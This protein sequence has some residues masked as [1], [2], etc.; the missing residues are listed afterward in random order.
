MHG[1][2]SCQER[3]SKRAIEKIAS[4][5]R[6][7]ASSSS[8]GSFDQQPAG[9]LAWPGKSQIRFGNDAYRIEHL[10][11]ILNQRFRT[12]D[13]PAKTYALKEIFLFLNEHSAECD[14]QEG[15]LGFPKKG[16]YYPS[17]YTYLVHAKLNFSSDTTFEILNRLN[18][19][20][21]FA[22]GPYPE[23]EKQ[24][25]QFNL[26][27][28]G[29][30]IAG[31]LKEKPTREVETT[32]QYIEPPIDL[33]NIA[34]EDLPR[35]VP[36]P[37]EVLEKIEQKHQLLSEKSSGGEKSKAKAWLNLVLS[38]P[39]ITETKDTMDIR[40]A[41]QILDRDFYGMERLKRRI[42][43]EIAK[44]KQQGSNQGG[45]LLLVGPPGTGKTAIA[46]IIAES[47]GR[48]FVRRSLSGINDA[49]RITGSDYT[50][51]GSK[52]GV[53]I[54]GM[55]EVGTINPVFQID[56]MDKVG[57]LSPQGNPLD[58]L[59]AVLDPQQNHSFTDS[60]LDFPYDLSKVLFIC[61]AN[62]LE[63]FPAPLLSR[64]EVIEFHAYMPEEKMA[65]ATNCLIPKLYKEFNLSPKELRFEPEAIKRIILHYTLEGGVRKL[66]ERLKG[67]FGEACLY[68]EE[69]PGERS[70]TVTPER[71]D[72]W[73]TDP[74]CKNAVNPV[75]MRK[76][77][78]S[79]MYYSEAGGG[80]MPVEV[81]ATNGK[82]Q[83]LLTGSLG[84][85]M[86]EAAQV[87]LSY[88]RK[89]HDTL[90]LSPETL[91]TLKED[92]IDIHIHYPDGATPKDGPSAGV[93]T[94]LALWS[95]LS[96]NRIPAGIALTGEVDLKGNITAIGG[97]LEKVSGAIQQGASKIYLPQENEKT[98][99]DI[100]KRSPIFAETVKSARIRFVSNVKEL[101]DDVRQFA[102]PSKS[103][104]EPGSENAFIKKAG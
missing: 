31:I 94:F 91:K 80:I 2:S 71:V 67:I 6:F 21:F 26:S 10:L 101:V 30:K 11:P 15:P 4:P 65:I 66:E 13:R 98:F 76:G 62:K 81:S 25:V 37:P 45:I 97:V 70:I 72:E 92:E 5:L 9:S 84:D 7:T 47:M 14:G 104:A 93:S 52:T 33:K 74:I 69:H 46:K 48:K 83:L 17:R 43:R 79:G 36:F 28:Y 95:E 24:W 16:L 40:K 54:D 8:L 88:I 85:V 58:A 87:A 99:H 56:E 49:Q 102:E 27:P 51:Q 77:V 103:Q 55:R 35:I 50:Y 59:L 42:I 73:L 75:E 44:R 61:T 41:S 57:T 39:W 78:A 18:E 53:I 12:E 19:L 20:N 68:R 89:N 63:D 100:C 34:I 1:R 82:G 3:A 23:K 64:T 90:G 86:K 60:Y 96:D 22:P 32:I 29:K 38:L